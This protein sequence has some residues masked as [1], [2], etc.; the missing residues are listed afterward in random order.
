MPVRA[1][2]VLGHF[3]ISPSAFVRAP[4]G[5]VWVADFRSEQ[6]YRIEIAL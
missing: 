3:D 1:V 5:R 2:T 6:V 4:D